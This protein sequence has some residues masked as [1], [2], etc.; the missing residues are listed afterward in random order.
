[1]LVCIL[2][3]FIILNLV[4]GLEH[5]FS[6]YIYI[7]ITAST[8]TESG[9]RKFALTAAFRLQFKS[10]RP[11]RWTLGSDLGGLRAGLDLTARGPELAGEGPAGW[12]ILP[13]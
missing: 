4:G 6:T 3:F 5:I 2:C 9:G 12:T 11:F 10:R 7:Y 8:P 1:M 13:C